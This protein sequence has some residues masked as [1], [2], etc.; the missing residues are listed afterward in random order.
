MNY[1]PRTMHIVLND[2]AEDSRVLKCA[3]SL[4][5]AGWNVLVCGARP[6]HHD[7]QLKIGYAIIDRVH[8]KV[9]VK[10]NTFAFILRALRYYKRKFQAKFLPSVPPAIPNLL[11]SKLTLKPIALEFKPD[12]IHAHD[13]T[14]LPVAGALIEYLATQGHTAQLIYDAHEYVPGVSHLTA[15]LKKVYIREEKRY[16]AVAATV[17]S[18]S[19]GMSDL[20]IPHLELSNRPELVANDPLFEGQQPCPRNLRQDCKIDTTTPLLVYSGAVAP[21]RGL[22]TVLEALKDLQGVHLALIANPKNQTVLDLQS[23]YLQLQDRFHVLAYV[24]NSELVSY[25]SAGDIGLI[26]IHHKLNHEISLITKFGE[27]MQ[28]HL[29]I[30]V[31]DVRTMAAEVK[32]LGNGE[33]FTAEDVADFA[34]A[35]KKVLADRAKYQSAYTEKVLLERSWELQAQHLVNIYNRIANAKPTARTHMPFTVIT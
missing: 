19:E 6:T 28:A 17:L 35:V 15:P 11:R 12:V 7:D 32:R 1:L 2:V 8:L 30:V 16:S 24:P 25:L 9:V 5:N 3:W 23:Q 21:Q 20:L 26:P 13:Y 33:V 14:A 18:V 10:Q 34:A 4:A 31:S 22:S 29:P 27:Y